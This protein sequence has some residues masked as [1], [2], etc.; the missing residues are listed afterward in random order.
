MAVTF[1]TSD[2]SLEVG[3]NVLFC[4]EKWEEKQIQLLPS[5]RKKDSFSLALRKRIV[6]YFG[7]GY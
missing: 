6:Y 5:R 3:I 4:K 2:F 7:G 1:M